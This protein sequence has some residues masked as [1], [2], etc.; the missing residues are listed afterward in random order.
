MHTNG[1]NQTLKISQSQMALIVSSRA[2]ITQPN[3]RKTY[4]A[5][6]PSLTY[7]HRLDDTRDNGSPKTTAR[8]AAR[9]KLRTVVM[10][11]TVD[12]KH[13]FNAFKT[14]ERGA[15]FVVLYETGK[16]VA[17]GGVKTMMQS[18]IG[19]NCVNRYKPN[20]ERNQWLYIRSD[21]PRSKSVLA[22]GRIPPPSHE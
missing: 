12:A 13:R 4:A 20:D 10:E 15:W 7:N 22:P 18:I 6:L 8:V 21:A 19:K 9:E 16:R 3:A 1:A 11:I 14:F 5:Y 17:R 2:H